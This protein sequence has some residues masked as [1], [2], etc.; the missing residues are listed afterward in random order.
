MRRNIYLIT[1]FTMFVLT[2]KAQ[3]A[4]W[5]EN[6]GTNPVCANVLASAYTSTNGA[7]TTSLTGANQT[8]PNIW[9][10]SATEAGMGVG[11]CGSGC[12]TN[13]I[14][15]NRT[16]HISTNV[17]DLGAAYLAGIGF[18]SDIRAQSP[19]INCSGKSGIVLNFNYIMW[20]V[21]NQ[22]YCQIMYSADNGVTWLNLG[23]PP[24]TPTVSCTGQ[25]LWTAHTV[26]LPVSAN[27]NSTVKVGFRWQNIN[28]TGA[29]PSVAVDDVV[30]TY[31]AAVAPSLTPTFSLQATICRGDSTQVTANTGTNVASG[32]TWSAV[33]A[34]PIF[35]APNA[36]VT[37]IKF[38]TAANYTITLT[39]TS[40]TMIGSVS[41][42]ITVNPT[43]TVSAFSSTNVICNGNSA[44]LTGSGAINYTWTPG[45]MTVSP[46]TVSPTVTTMYQIVG[47]NSFGCKGYGSINITVIPKP[48]IGISSTTM[49]VCIGSSATITAT[50]ASTYSWA[51]NS[52][53]LAILVVSP[54]VNTT[55]TVVGT[56]S[57]G[58]T[59]TNTITITTSSCSGG[60]TG[61]NSYINNELLYSVFPNPLKDKMIIKVGDANMS[62]VKV[63]LFDVVG[64]K[65]FEQNLNSLAAGTEQSIQVSSLPKG[66]FILQMNVDGKAQKAMRLVKE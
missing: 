28:A 21:I 1:I 61:L 52:S 11:N 2:N 23:I 12:S 55:Y 27:N 26:A 59:N 57:A 9:Y 39:A 53:S 25:G 51:P 24:Q 15:I 36:S 58:C 6:F 64:K 10:V 62:N 8:F 54:S 31:T 22:D 50:G 56:S 38:N 20:G 44:V 13:P 5:T 60:G 32:Y 43:P 47:T 63:E 37:Y 4:F 14:L 29:D 7:W 66:V 42:S 19:T 18:N 17:G 40:G 65:L 34:G 45:N 46:V 3:T 49:N 33:P 41:H 48:T 30:L 35:S 16:L